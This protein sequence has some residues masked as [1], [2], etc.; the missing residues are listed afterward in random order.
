MEFCSDTM[1]DVDV[2]FEAMKLTAIY[3]SSEIDLK[4][5]FACRRG[6]LADQ[7]TVI[8]FPNIPSDSGER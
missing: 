2:S 3:W 4:I 8:I 6:I 5:R 7:K 1:E